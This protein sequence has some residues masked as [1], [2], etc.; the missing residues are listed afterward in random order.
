MFEPGCILKGNLSRTA[1][2]KN[3]AGV[4]RVYEGIYF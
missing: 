2:I 1:Q 3:P 4:H